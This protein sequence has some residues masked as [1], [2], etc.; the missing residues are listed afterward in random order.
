MNNKRLRKG[1]LLT[2]VLFRPSPAS[3]EICSN[4]SET[5]SIVMCPLCDRLCDFW[6]LGDSCA[7]AYITFLFDNPATVFFSIA[8]SFWGEFFSN[9][10][11]L[12]R[13]RKENPFAVF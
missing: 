8:M 12:V 9:T 2:R 3:E 7:N 6:K 4:T 1:L 13:K 10:L 11:S 5:S